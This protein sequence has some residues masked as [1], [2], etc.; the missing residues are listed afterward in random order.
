VLFRR[1]HWTWCNGI[2]RR[3]TIKGQLQ[4]FHV[5]IGIAIATLV[6]LCGLNIL[7]VG[8][9][10]DAREVAQVAFASL[11]AQVVLAAN[12]YEARRCLASNALMSW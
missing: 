8:Y 11:G 5:R 4:P 2:D 3:N 9:E 6:E 7:L 10:G 12:G 1:F